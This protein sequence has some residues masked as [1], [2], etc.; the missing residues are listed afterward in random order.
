MSEPLSERARQRL[1][2]MAADGDAAPVAPGPVPE[3]YELLRELGRG[4][5]GVVYEAFDHQLGRRCALKT[6]VAGRGHGDELRRRLEREA[7]AAARLRHPHIAAVH[8][9]TADYISMQLVDGVPIDTVHR[10]ERRLLV[11][12]VRDAAHALQHAHDQGVVHRDVKPSNLLVEGRHVYVVDFGLAKAAATDASW[13]LPGGVVGTPGFMA[14]EQARG[15][16][17]EVSARSDVYGLGATLFAC[18]RGAPPFAGDDLPAL[19]RAVIEDEPPRLGVDRDLDLVVGKCL[20]KEPMQRYA[21]AGELAADLERWLCGEPVLARAPSWW[22]RLQKRLQRQRSLWRAAAVAAL[23]SVALV[24]VVVVPWLL[25]E[26]AARTAASEAVE[27]ADHA[28]TVLRDAAVYFRLGDNESAHQVLDGGIGSTRE[29]L[30]RH[31]VPRARYLLSRLLRA[32]GRTDDARS[33]LDRAVAGDP[34]LGDAR[35]ERGL[36]LAA[37][38][39]PEPAARAQAIADLAVAPDP[40][41]VLT[42]VDRLFGRGQSLRLCGEPAAAMAVL[43]EVLALDPLHVPARVAM[44]HA[45]IAAGDDELGRYYSASAVDCYSGYG[46]L[47]AARERR[48][49]PTTM[50]GLEPALVDFARELGD[51]EDLVLTLAQRALLHLRRALRFAGDGDGAAARTAITAAI[52]DHD[53]AL[54]T[55]AMQSGGAAELPGAGNNRAVCR[56]VAAQLFAAAGDGAG[57]AAERTQAIAELERLLALAP[58]PEVPFNLGIAELQVAAIELGLGRAAAAAARGQAA[59][60]WFEQALAVAA[61]D[62]PHAAAGRAKLAAAAALLATARR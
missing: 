43:R 11:E 38:A 54:A 39:E 55:R 48:A 29:F 56:L 24:A 10:S 23:A 36:L 9:A 58:L 62:W 57:A 30:S 28:A 59:H 22:Y 20:A 31:E 35:F 5:M 7:Q 52:A 45:A 13:S 4:G 26:S 19:L 60:R 50:L 34:A 1:L 32:R 8:D 51:D 44:A 15:A 61:P 40:R 47:Y 14:P 41:S 49:L 21:S 33:E 16:A 42:S 17:A 6:F 27:V 3:R 12:L 37:A 25:R 46:P 53:T 2:A 18:L